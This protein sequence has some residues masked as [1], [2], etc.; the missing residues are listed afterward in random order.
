MQEA[1]VVK[2]LLIPGLRIQIT[3]ELKP[4]CS[5][6]DSKT[7]SD[8]TEYLE[9]NTRRAELAFELYSRSL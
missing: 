3:L 4:E 1:V 2:S 6:V 8:S 5:V 9:G 7:S